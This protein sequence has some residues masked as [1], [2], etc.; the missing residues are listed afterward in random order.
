LRSIRPPGSLPVPGSGI[1]YPGR[2]ATGSRC[3][4]S[5]IRTS[6]NA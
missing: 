3:S 5:R 2:S 6:A 4:S 1:G